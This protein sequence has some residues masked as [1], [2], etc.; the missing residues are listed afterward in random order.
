MFFSYAQLKI[1]QFN[2]IHMT[3]QYV[4]LRSFLNTHAANG[5]NVK[6]KKERKKLK[7]MYAWHRYS[8]QKY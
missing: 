4:V 3:N 6:F 5:R 1:R 7:N 8:N 2:L